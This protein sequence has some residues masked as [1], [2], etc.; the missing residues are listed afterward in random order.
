[1]ARWVLPVTVALLAFS[2]IMSNRV[3]SDTWYVPWNLAMAALLLALAF[4][5]GHRRADQLGLARRDLGSGLRWGA[6]LLAAVA[7]VYVVAVVLPPTHGLFHDRRVGEVGVGTMLFAA[8]VRI[9]LGTVVLE[10]VAFRSVL[11]ALFG[12]SRGRWRAA[13]AASMLFGLW[14][15][16]PAWHLNKVN[17]VASTAF[18]GAS[19][20][21]IAVS[22][23]VIG[24]A[25]AGMFF[26]WLRYRSR[27]VIAPAMLHLA[28]N[29]LG[30]LVA[31][32]VWRA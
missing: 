1:M 11:P 21:A 17:P 29:S 26:C 2:N 8:L 19:G 15:V 30:Y 23:G 31:W 28:T 25:A 27:S 24:T 13:W 14:H 9:P 20:Q 32:F 12:A 18:A 7:L 3:L 10:E 6:V 22:F 16:L 4:G 5:P